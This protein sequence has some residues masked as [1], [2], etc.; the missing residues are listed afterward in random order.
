MATI[1]DIASMAGVSPAAVSRILNNDAGL[2]VTPATRKRVLD[3][4]AQLGYT[5]KKTRD[6][7]GFKMGILQWFSAEEELSDDYYLSI[8]KGIEDYCAA[9]A[10][11]L[12][13]AYRVDGVTGSLPDD[14]DGVICVGKFSSKDAG[15][16]ISKYKNILFLDMEVEHPEVTTITMDFKTAVK[17]ALSYLMRL[18]H[19]KIAYIGG[20]EYPSGQS[21]DKAPLEDPRKKAYES[22]MRKHKLEYKQL[23]SEGSFSAE[24]G[25]EQMTALI[26]SGNVPEAVLAASDAIA[27]GVLKAIADKGLRCP[28]DI[29][30]MGIN[31]D[32]MSAFTTPSLTTMRAPAYDMGQHGANLVYA[33]G[34]LSINTPLKVMIPCVLTERDSCAERR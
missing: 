4:A 3:C 20:L 1:R 32:R 34:N 26:D 21:R 15:A 24:S 33:A 5:R 8:R 9:N 28:E 25:Y 27:V 18:G 17:E 14:T 2:S 11:S 19:R 13:R 29:S 31:D 7:S 16:L 23:L 22:F 6:K 12:S 30:V 10:I